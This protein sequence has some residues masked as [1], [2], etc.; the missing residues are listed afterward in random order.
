MQENN[1]YKINHRYNQNNTPMITTNDQRPSVKSY[2]EQIE[3]MLTRWHKWQK[4]KHPQCQP[5][6]FDEI[7]ETDLA[8]QLQQLELNNKDHQPGMCDIDDTILQQLKEYKQ[9]TN[10]M[11]YHIKEEHVYIREQKKIL[12]LQLTIKKEDQITIRKIPFSCHNKQESFKKNRRFHLSYIYDNVGPKSRFNKKL[13]EILSKHVQLPNTT[14]ENNKLQLDIRTKT[15]WVDNYAT[16]SYLRDRIRE[17]S[18]N[19]TD[20][21]A[22]TIGITT[23]TQ[24]SSPPPP[25]NIIQNE[26]ISY[27]TAN[28]LFG[29]GIGIAL[30]ILLLL[31]NLVMILKKRSNYRKKKE[32]ISAESLRFHEMFSDL[33]HARQQQQQQQQQQQ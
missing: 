11:N 28:I 7:M 10:S 6:N 5:I 33:N 17:I 18:G 24:S 27:P 4:D 15:V 22:L 29:F 31:I 13:R 9:K 8:R 14:F 12:Q 30:I 32:N 3:T 23:T 2:R 20:E 26:C 25:L 16:I 21:A 1:L 19:Y